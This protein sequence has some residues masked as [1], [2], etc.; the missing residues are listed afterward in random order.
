MKRNFF[1]NSPL[2]KGDKGGCEPEVGAI[3]SGNGRRN[4]ET[5]PFA[6]FIKGEYFGNYVRGL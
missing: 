5:T 1:I 2:E 4:Q 6:P 3:I